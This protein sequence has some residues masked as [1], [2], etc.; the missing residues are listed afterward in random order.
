M[1]LIHKLAARLKPRAVGINDEL[2]L[3]SVDKKKSK[4]INFL[5]GSVQSM[6]LAGI[7]SFHTFLVLYLKENNYSEFQIGLIMTLMSVIGVFSPTIIGYIADYHIPIK[8]IVVV[9]ITLSIPLAFMVQAAVAFY[10]IAL[11][12]ILLTGIAEKGMGSVID[13]WGMRLRGKH[14][15]L[16]YGA[17]RGLASLSY[18]IMALI[19]GR[20]YESFGLDKMFLVH[21]VVAALCVMFAMMLDNVPTSQK[22]KESKSFF[23][24]VRQLLYIRQYSI[25]LIVMVLH[26]FSMVVI[27][28]F[29]PI[30]ISDH[31]GTSVHLGISSFVLA[32]SEVPV[33]YNS[34]RFLRRFRAESLIT[35]SLFFATIRLLLSVL[36]PSLGW[37]IAAQSLQALSFGLYLPSLLFYIS[38]ITPDDMQSTAITLALSIGFGGSGIIG[39]FFGGILAQRFGVSSVY[40]LFALLAACGLVLFRATRKAP[41]TG[42]VLRNNA[43]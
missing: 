35:V 6:Y 40:Y 20:I 38:L 39:N 28:T 36:A 8:M 42:A 34:T 10:P 7:C 15:Y 25:L 4:R 2:P 37:L 12:V 30:L 31:G 19:A 23:K 33:M 27:G 32:A 13:S 14:P 41:A 29:Q 22:T 3:S 9:L 43:A 21:A 11:V 24:T 16:N 18:A 17:T 26:G 5:Y 1:T